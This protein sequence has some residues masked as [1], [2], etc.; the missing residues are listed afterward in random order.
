MIPLEELCIG[1]I[2]PRREECR[3]CKIDEGNKNCPNYKTKID[4]I[5]EK[6][7]YLL[8]NLGGTPTYQ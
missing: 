2:T 6:Q 5:L 1:H 3:G 4:V 7:P 8:Q